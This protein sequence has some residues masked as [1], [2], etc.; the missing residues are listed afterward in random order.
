MQHDHYYRNSY[1]SLILKN[2]RS[3]SIS[4]NFLHKINYPN[5]RY[6]KKSFNH[7]SLSNLFPKISSQKSS[8]LNN[9]IKLH[10]S[11]QIFFFPFHERFTTNKIILQPLF[12]TEPL[13]EYRFP[14]S[15]CKGVVEQFR[16]AS[17]VRQ[18]CPGGWNPLAAGSLI[19]QC[20]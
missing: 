1:F 2:D 15:T 18:T 20:V 16:E 5:F 3:Q 14:G 19:N 13:K 10:V 6:V 8:I 11:G 9:T 7:P 12:T 4:L 17:F